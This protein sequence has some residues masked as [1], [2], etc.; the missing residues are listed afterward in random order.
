MPK[1]ELRGFD[2]ILSL[3][4]NGNYLPG[5]LERNE[6]LISEIAAFTNTYGTKA[7]GKLTIEIDY[8]VDR[9]GQISLTVDDKIKSPKAPKA[10]AVAWTSEGGVL[11]VANPNQRQMEIRDVSG[12]RELRVPHA[13]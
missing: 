13:D 12:G 1:D 6:G 8:E 5:L 10:K 7:K 2:Q 11:T 4:D 3:A 9:F